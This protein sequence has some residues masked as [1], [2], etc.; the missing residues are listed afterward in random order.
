[1]FAKGAVLFLYGETP[2]HLGSGAS[3]KTNAAVDLPIQREKHTFYP[4]GQG[5]GIKGCFKD[6]AKKLHLDEKKIEIVFG[7]E[8]ERSSDHGGALSFSDARILLFPIRSVAGVFAWVTCPLVIERLKLDVMRAGLDLGDLKDINLSSLGEEVALVSLDDVNRSEV[9]IGANKV[10]LEEF[11][12]DVDG[13]KT[14]MVK[15]LVQWL[16]KN[17]LPTITGNTGKDIYQW[18]KDKLK[19]SLV[20]VS[21]NVFRDFV[22]FSTEVFTRVKIHTD[23]GTV[24]TGPW[25]EEYLPPETL[26][27][28][29]LLSADPKVERSQSINLGLQDAKAIFNFLK[30][31]V[32][33]KVLVVQLGGDETLGKGFARVTLFE[34]S[35]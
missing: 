1:M 18:W 20:V 7:P 4:M 23:K 2:L 31:Q 33:E 21:N 22:E 34:G 3:V 13:T 27:Y 14:E 35:G 28:C 26:L 9:I 5:S 30:Q 6:L 8:G 10:I 32:I 17:A 16:C 24:E 11:P 15:K 19:T 29:V 25:D 12:F